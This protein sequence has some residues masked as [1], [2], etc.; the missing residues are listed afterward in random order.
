MSEAPLVSVVVA[1]RDGAAY[2]EA[3]VRSALAQTHPRVEVIVVDDGSTDDSAAIA[4]SIGPPVR[5]VRQSPGGAAAARNGGV[6][7]ARGDL[8][9][10]LDADDLW[11]VDRLERQVAALTE[12]PAIDLVFGSLLEFRG[13]APPQTGAAPIAPEPAK[14]GGTLLAR[15]AALARVGP[16]ATGWRVG[17]FMEWLL[18]AREAGLCERTIG[19]LVLWRR[20]HGAN[21]T[22]AERAGFGQYAQI[23]KASL[24]RRRAEAGR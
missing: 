21:Q 11:P 4:E 16:F 8:I 2:L 6:A 10:F 15:R 5:C 12:D 7:L 1:V 14:L 20:I 23:L 9:A 17:E 18:R 3:A 24:D 19:A 22:I 13:D